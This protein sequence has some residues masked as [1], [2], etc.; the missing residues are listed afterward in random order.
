MSV[1][2]LG[3]IILSAF[4]HALWNTATKGSRS[5]MAFLLALEI[6]TVIVGLPL[7]LWIDLGALPARF[8]QLAAATSVA[9]GLYAYCLTRAYTDGDLSLVYPISRS[10]PA[11]VP[12]P[13]VV[14]LGERLSIVG[15]I[16]I[17]LVVV[18]LWTVQ[19][20]DGPLGRRLLDPGLRF[21]Y[22]TLAG[23]VTYS[24][25]DKEAMQVLDSSPWS[26]PV[27]PA[28]F[29]Y[30]LLSA[31]HLPLFWLLARKRVSLT[32][33]TGL[34]RGRFWRMI[35][36]VLAA[37]ASYALVLEALRIAP[38]SYVVA[39][40]QTSVVFVLLFALL[41][42]RESPGQRRIVGALVTVAGVVLVAIA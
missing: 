34:V 2:A 31:G 40:R 6:L 36:A 3:W 33:V 17:A 8:W 20:G 24:L 42:L 35:G 9:H 26:S 23:T 25:I 32:E 19:A 29:Y 12:I 37:F 28:V 4:L 10:S 30:F 1:L 13:A 15:V 21:A 39:V 18:G 27:P 7:L 5:P 11:F 14:L 41:W 16:G 22:W 38:V